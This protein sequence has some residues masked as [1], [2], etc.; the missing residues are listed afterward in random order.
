EGV[1]GVGMFYFKWQGQLT[2]AVEG[3]S[4]CKMKN[5]KCKSQ[6][7]KGRL[8]GMLAEAFIDW[9]ASEVLSAG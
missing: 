8:T 2:V 3:T 4:K 5:A 7:E 9:T 6:N 1:N